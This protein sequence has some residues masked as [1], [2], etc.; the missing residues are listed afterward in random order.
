MQSEIHCSE[1]IAIKCIRCEL[2][3]KKVETVPNLQFNITPK[4][5]SDEA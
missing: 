3:W 4:N 2:E 1:K 5:V